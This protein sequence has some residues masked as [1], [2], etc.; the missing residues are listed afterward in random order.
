M[1]PSPAP[2]SPPPPL[3]PGPQIQQLEA[4]LAQ[5]GYRDLYAPLPPENPLDMLELT[6]G[7]RHQQPQH[8]GA[9]SCR[10]VC[11]GDGFCM[12]VWVVLGGSQQRSM[13]WCMRFCQW[14]DG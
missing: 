11:A 4:T 12:Q 7:Q 8:L 5:Y 13:P 1:P 9:C 10:V 6:R 14:T 2:T 3:L